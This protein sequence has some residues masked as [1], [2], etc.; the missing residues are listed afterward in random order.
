MNQKKGAK[1]WI[2]V[3]IILII[4][5]VVVGVFALK[6]SDETKT[7]DDQNAAENKATLVS[8]EDDQEQQDEEEPV[9]ER[10]GSEDFVIL[11]VDTRTEEIPA[12]TNS[13]SIMIV[14]VD[15]DKKEVKV[16][17]I[18]RD[19]MVHIEDQAYQKITH[20]HAIGGADLALLTVNQNFDLD[21]EHYLV[22]NFINVQELVDEI[23]GVVH[24]I[25]E[26]EVKH[27]SGINGAYTGY[28]TE[29]GTYQLD[30]AQAVAYSRI[31]KAAGGDYKRAER[32]RE[33][34]F[35]I[36]E[37]A[38]TMSVDERISLADS[39]LSKVKSNFVR[40]DL[41][42]LL[43]YLSKYEMTETSAYPQVF[44]AGTVSGNWVEVPVTL[45]D[46]NASLHEFLFDDTDYTPSDAVLEYSGVLEGKVEGP[47]T[48]LREDKEE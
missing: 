42:S 2:P 31:R 48:D 35:K 40:D 28:I 38:K 8:E 39:M 17:S 43:Y 45:V 29:A 21:I 3:V 5:L 18:Y 47:N 46:L 1:L 6:S 22:L 44:Y 32:Q 23:G 7:S 25:D 15:H 14:H 13:D 10:E 16:A 9:S 19:C 26:D 4:V 11:G 20:A 12:G 34:L 33:I 27:L 37:K 41:T 36:F 30:G 24:D